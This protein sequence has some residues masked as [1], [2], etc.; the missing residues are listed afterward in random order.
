MTTKQLNDDENRIEQDIQPT[1]I[2]NTNKE[3]NQN[4]RLHYTV[5]KTNKQS[6]RLTL[7]KEEKPN[8]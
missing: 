7:F 5:K 6:P 2:I 3:N 4:F 1:F 8:K